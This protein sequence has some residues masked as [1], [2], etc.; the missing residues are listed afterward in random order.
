M[1]RI[2]RITGFLAYVF[3][4]PF[5]LGIIF[6]LLSILNQRTV[7]Q[8]TP[9]ATAEQVAEKQE[10]ALPPSMTGME[11]M[12]Y[13]NREAKMGSLKNE[14][15]Q[16][17][18]QEIEKLE[19][20]DI[21]NDPNCIMVPATAVRYFIVISVKPESVR[22]KE[23]GCCP[24]TVDKKRLLGIPDLNIVEYSGATW[25]QIMMELCTTD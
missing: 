25:K 4:I 13:G 8:T 24:F 3:G 16:M 21:I 5:G 10:P 20:G 17:R 23:L 7:D 12:I 6:F 11:S 1:S 22:I 15:R 2:R 18:L 14:Q 19:R 9:P